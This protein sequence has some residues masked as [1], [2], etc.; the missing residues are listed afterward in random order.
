RWAERARQE[1]RATGETSREPDAG[2]VEQLTPQELEI[3]TLA[4]A[5]LT[6]REIGQRLYLSHRTVGSHLYHVFP[7]LGITSRSELAAALGPD[8][9]WRSAIRRAS[10]AGA[11]LRVHV[12]VGTLD[13][14][15]ELVLGRRHRHADARLRVVRTAVVVDDVQGATNPLDQLD[16][17][18]R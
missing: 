15:G 5:G 11:L 13:Q 16:R 2:A 6:N 18:G 9:D 8:R 14:L 3:A 7:K 12:D 17:V 4:A 10:P 1:L